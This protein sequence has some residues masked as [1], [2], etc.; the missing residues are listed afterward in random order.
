MKTDQYINILSQ[1]LPLSLEACDM[2]N[3]NIIIQ[4][5]ND[6]KHTS[7]PAKNWFE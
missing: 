5:D 2:E 1:Y 7:N 4:Q 3:A 6:L